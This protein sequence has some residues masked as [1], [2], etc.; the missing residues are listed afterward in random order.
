M[1][2]R[3]KPKSKK[4]T[5][6]TPGWVW[7][8][9]GLSLG[10]VVAAAIYVSD[11]RAP[12]PASTTATRQRAPQPAPPEPVVETAPDPAPISEE[13]EPGTRFDFYDMLPQFEVVIPEIETNPTRSTRATA[14]EEPGSYVLQTGSFREL[15]DA[16]R[17]QANLALLGIESR[18]QRVAIDDDIY[19][20]VRVGPTEN[21]ADL[22]QIR[23]RL[24][25]AEI[26]FLT[27]QMP[28]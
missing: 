5:R 25:D 7:M 20:R 15:A 11:R 4:P 13:T 19:H 27:I 24:W 12:V 10:L 21:L 6:Q 28:N 16:D 1:S 22:N 18:I 9:F 3:K 26:E 14:V 2:T 17:M 23:R 8:F